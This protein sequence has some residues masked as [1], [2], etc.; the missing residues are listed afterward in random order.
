MKIQQPF[1]LKTAP[2]IIPPKDG[3][4]EHTYYAVAVSYSDSN[5]VHIAVLAIGFLNKDKPAGYSKVWTNNYDCIC[6][7]SEAYY[8]KV[9]LELFT[10][11]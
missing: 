9:I 5:P 11:E 8:L 1:E 10:T 6:D 7:F 2:E 3:W 4:K